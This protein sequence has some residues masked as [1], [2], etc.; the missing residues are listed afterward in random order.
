MKKIVSAFLG[1]L[2]LLCF[3]LV[4]FNALAES[5][6]CE[7]PHYGEKYDECETRYTLKDSTVH[8][9]YTSACEDY[10]C[11]GY[12]TG[13]NTWRLVGKSCGKYDL[14]RSYLNSANISG[15]AGIVKNDL[16]VNNACVRMTTSQ[17]TAINT[18]A[19][20]CD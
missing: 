11:Y 5:E 12:A 14:G 3:L 10:N 20:Y 18:P 16:E 13:T 19:A 2:F 8:I 4:P 9:P 7:V 6:P 15:L 1:C 17:S